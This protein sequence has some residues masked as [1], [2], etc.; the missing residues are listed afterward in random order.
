MIKTRRQVKVRHL[1]TVHDVRDTRVTYKE[2]RH[3]SEAGYDLALINC[4]PGDTTLA[5]VRVIGLGAPR[6]RLH[7]MFVKSVSMARRAL[8]ENA[9]IYHFHDPELIPVGIVLKLRG[10]RVIYDVH[11]DVPKQ[12]MHKFWIPT[13]M[14][15]PL[16]LAAHVFERAATRLVDL[17]V[18]ATPT[19]AEK[20]PQAKTIVCQ[21]FPE[22][23]LAEHKNNTPF[24]D[25]PS[26]FVYVGGL[27]RQQGL[28]SMLDGAA[29]LPDDAVGDLAGKF[30]EYEDEARAH[31]GWQHVRW[32]GVLERDGIVALLNQARTGVVLNHPISNYLEA[33]STKMFEY[34]ACGL[35]VVTSD[36]PLWKE[37]VEGSGCGVAVDPFDAAAVEAAVRRYLDDPELAASDGERG[38]QAILARYNWS[39]EGAKLVAAYDALC[40]IRPVTSQIMSEH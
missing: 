19:I 8:H 10:K 37:I 24:E 17:F 32:H 13:P 26:A 33:Y 4:N 5:G 23:D 14:K 40:G 11:E 28:F 27:S 12:I 38:R 18:A 29:Q 35:P 22:K 9:D 7:R 2:C 30:K 1:S 34:M 39:L 21:N 31:P 25:R 6:N 20:F 15:K 3:L 16:S 36:I